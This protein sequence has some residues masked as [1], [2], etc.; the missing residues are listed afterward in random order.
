VSQGLSLGHV[1]SG[2][3]PWTKGNTM[4]PKR[5]LLLLAAALVAATAFAGNA[6][7]ATGKAPVL[8]REQLGPWFGGPST[9]CTVDGSTL[10]IDLALRGL[11]TLPYSS[12][13]TAGG[14]A[15]FALYGGE[16]YLTSLQIGFTLPSTIGT[17]TGTIAAAPTTKGHADCEPASG[18]A[19]IEIRG[20]VYTAQLPDGTAD[21][22]VVDIVLSS[23]NGTF[24]I[25]FDSTRSP[26]VDGDRDGVWDG[27]DNCET[28][29]NADQRDVDV[30]FVGDVCDTYD[31]RPALTLLGEL[32]ADTRAVK[33]GSKLVAKVDHAI[34]AL[35]A[36]DVATACTDVAAYISQLQSARGKT[37]PVATADVLLAKARHIRAVLG[38]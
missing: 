26:E 19:T 21:S 27:D 37:I 20:A 32:W 33:N 23:A 30:D 6:G 15:T 12:T 2:A 16:G 5:L 3:Q 24:T 10:T 8:D 7:A 9:T 31:D 18:S 36:G 1:R 11:S 28:V 35:Q 14:A 38:C 13:F 4:T 34:Q 17:V 29:A 22:G 25:M